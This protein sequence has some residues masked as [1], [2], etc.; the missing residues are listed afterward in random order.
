MM[1]PARLALF[2]AAALSATLSAAAVA[3][4][5]TDPAGSEARASA[6]D[7][8][9]ARAAADSLGR[10]LEVLERRL[11]LRTQV[12]GD[13]DS[14]QTRYRRL[15]EREREVARAAERWLR[16][17]PSESPV[18]GGVISSAMSP[19]RYHP[20][21]LRVIPHV[22]IDIAAPAG[23]PVLATAD[24]TV[25]ATADH[26]TYGLTV[27]LRHGDSGFMTRAA[28]LSR[29]D[30]RPGDPVRR[31]DVIGA[32]GSTGLSTG[33]HVHFEVFFRG[34]RQDPIRYMPPGP[35][36]EQALLGVD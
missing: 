29:I 3:G 30:V 24:G 27:D 33:P 17:V 6:A 10:R 31:G 34:W 25:W 26:P 18:Q 11:G 35:V 36:A 28:H 16:F 4:H 14:L 20:I 1:T 22:G 15:R 19:G 8:R 32:V 7:R 9:L 2:T 5:P 23:E 21:R 12:G 13:S